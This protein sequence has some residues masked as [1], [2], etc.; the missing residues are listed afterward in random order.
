LKKKLLKWYLNLIFCAGTK[1]CTIRFAEYSSDY[2]DSIVVVEKKRHEQPPH[3][4][5]TGTPSFNDVRRKKS[6]LW[7]AMRRIFPTVL[8][9]ALQ[10][11]RLKGYSY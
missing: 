11:L 10:I 5:M 3:A 4:E 9:K 1:T 8:N 6:F 7:R 2:Y